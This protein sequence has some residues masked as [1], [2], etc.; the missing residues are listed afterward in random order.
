MRKLFF[1]LLL[2]SS[3][4]GSACDA[5][6]CASMSFGLGDLSITNRH[7]IGVRYGL[8]SFSINNITDYY[9]QYEVNALYSLNSKWQLKLNL[10]YLMALRHEAETENARLSGLGDATLR[11]NYIPYYHIAEDNVQSWSLGLG[12]NLPTGHFQNRQNSAVASNFQTGT[13]SWDF[14]GE[15]RYQF[16]TKKW[17]WAVHAAYLYNTVNAAGYRF[18]N[19]V[20]GQLSAAYKITI[21]KR[22]LMP[23]LSL[24]YEHF[25]RDVN[26]R[27]YYQFNTGA[28]AVSLLAGV[29]LI[30][31]HWYGGVKG[32]TNIFNRST[33]SYTP[34][35]QLQISL[36]YLF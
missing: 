14:I 6:G 21:K 13:G 1:A 8:R 4:S 10:P 12:I 24:T 25:D 7:Y 11:V 16:S 5:C 20:N 18:G 23:L 31:Q 36:N 29:N 28:D 22:T 30:T 17:V 26:E 15:S 35:M 34:G 33:A 19:Q 32:G 3:L 9:H 27:G 2:L